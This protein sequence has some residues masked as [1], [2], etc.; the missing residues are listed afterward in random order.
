[1]GLVDSHDIHR[2]FQE[3]G[4]EGEGLRPESTGQRAEEVQALPGVKGANLKTMASVG[5]MKYQEVRRTREVTGPCYEMH[6]YQDYFLVFLNQ[7]SEYL[8]LVFGLE[9]KEVGPSEHTYILVP[10]LGLTLNE[11]LRDGQRFPKASLLVVILC[12][13]SVKDKHVPAEEI[14]GALSR[15][16]VCPGREHY[17][18][19]EPREL[20][21]QVWVREMYLE[22]QQVS[23]CNS[24]RYEFL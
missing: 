11:M 21:S 13:I 5:K 4:D 19:G 12:L 14:W 9:V 20:L 7:A 24:T 15:M 22:Y 1:M 10:T 17:I 8:Q 2:G 6:Y 3:P 23:H 16:A 18:Y